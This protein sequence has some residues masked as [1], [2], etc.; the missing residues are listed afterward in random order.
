MGIF[1]GGF[2]LYHTVAFQLRNI[3]K[4]N[5]KVAFAPCIPGK[6]KVLPT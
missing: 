5:E 3:G 4:E 1:I 2:F 6:G